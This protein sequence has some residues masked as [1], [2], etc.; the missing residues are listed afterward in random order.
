MEGYETRKLKLNVNRIKVMRCSWHVDGGRVN[1]SLNGKM[2]EEEDHFKYMGS[3][4]DR[5][6]GVEVDD[7]LRVG[8][9]RGLQA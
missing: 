9:L 2:L 3:Q 4:T 1:V 8:K 7:S 5:E 6:G